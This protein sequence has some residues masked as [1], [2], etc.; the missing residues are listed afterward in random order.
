MSTINCYGRRFSEA[1]AGTGTG[2]KVERNQRML[3]DYEK[4]AIVHVTG[5][6]EVLERALR[7]FPNEPLDLAD[8]AYWGWDYLT[9]GGSWQ[10]VHGLGTVEN[11]E[12][13]W[14]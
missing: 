8:A 12:S 7:R 10:D 13:R 11:F 5:T 9:T 6:H 14:K 2:G 1:K 3:V 4:G